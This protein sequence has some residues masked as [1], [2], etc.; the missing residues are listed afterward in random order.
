[1]RELISEHLLLRDPLP[2]DWEALNQLLTDPR[3]VRYMHFAAWS[4]QQRRDWF[5][6]CVSN[7]Q[8]AQPDAYNWIIIERSSNQLIGWL[9]IG[10][11]SHPSVAGERDF[12]YLLAASH[13]NKGL[14]SEALQCVIRYEFETLGTPYISATCETANPASARVMQKAGM[15]FVKT[16]FDSDSEGNWAERHHYAIAKSAE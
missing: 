4:E 7:A 16:V 13:W 10:G 11:A 8:V 14:M 12:G 1:M 3:V 9:G 5:A 15:E 2:E 6:W